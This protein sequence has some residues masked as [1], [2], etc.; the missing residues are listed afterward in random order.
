[1]NISYDQ[2]V[3]AL[4]IQLGED[5]P[6]GVTEMAEGVN[7]D[8]TP[9]GKVVGLEILEASKRIDLQ[10]ILR[11]HLEFDKQLFMQKAA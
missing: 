7:L 3:D 6:E 2:D 9:D 4:Y 10:T 1:M 11:Y 8:L 5:E